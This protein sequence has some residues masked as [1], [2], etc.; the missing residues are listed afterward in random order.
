MKV[1]FVFFF[2]P[3]VVLFFDFLPYSEKRRIFKCFIFQNRT[4]D[5]I[6]PIVSCTHAISI[7]QKTSSHSPWADR[8][9]V[10]ILGEKVPLTG[11]KDSSKASQPPENLNIHK[12]M[13]PDEMPPTVFRKLADEDTNSLSMIF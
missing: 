9:E 13:R 2:S 1:V 10:G 3:M 11:S 5:N 12:S 4:G 6:F 8:F 7:W